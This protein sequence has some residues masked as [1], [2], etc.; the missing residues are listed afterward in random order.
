MTKIKKTK[1]QTVIYK[2]QHEHQ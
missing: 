1:E 2:R